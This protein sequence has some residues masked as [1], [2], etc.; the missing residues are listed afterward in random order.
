MNKNREKYLNINSIKIINNKAI[1][2]K[3]QGNLETL[4]DAQL[5]FNKQ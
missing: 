1:R 3:E 5:K 2:K 4:R